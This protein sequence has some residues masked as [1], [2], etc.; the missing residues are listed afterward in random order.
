[1][2]DENL[3]WTNQLGAAVLAQLGDVMNAIQAMRAKAQQ[4][5]NLVSTP[6]QQVVDTDGAIQ[7]VP[8][9]PQVVYVPTYDPTVIY[10]QQAPPVPFITF[11]PALA[12]GIWIGGGFN[13][14]RHSFYR[15]GYWRPG[16]GW[17]YRGGNG[18][19]WP[20]TRTGRHPARPTDPAGR[21]KSARMAPAAEQRPGRPGGPGNRPGVPGIDPASLVIAPVD[22]A[23]PGNRPNPPMAGRIV[24]A[25]PASPATVPVDPAALEQA[26]SAQW[27]AESPRRSRPARQPSRWTR[28]PWK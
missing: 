4:L 23:G 21:E 18:V 6:Q 26:Q 24:P 13:W 10:V 5:G 16:Y 25:V 7:I 11:G 2:M 12:L 3:D 9:D 17:G 1:M 19:I 22:P 14:G 8:A 20:R 28:R 27:R 15:G